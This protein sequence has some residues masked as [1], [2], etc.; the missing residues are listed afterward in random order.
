MLKTLLKK[1][2]LELNRSFFYNSKKGKLRSKLSSAVF[3]LAYA[4]LMI[5]ILGVCFVYLSYTIC[6]PFTAAGLD[7]LYF[8]LM[9]LVAIAL[10]VFGSVFNTYSS[11]YK[12]NDND[13]LLSLPI[14][15]KHILISRL[16]G[17]YLIGLMFSGVVM[18]P[19][20]IV[21]YAVAKPGA[22]AIIGSIL[23]TL[24]ISIFVL[25]LSCLLG[26]VVAKL[27]TRLKN[28]SL[29]IVVLSLL[30]IA[31]YYYIYY[32]AGSMLQTLL[33]SAVVFGEEIK[34]SAAVLYFIGLC[35]AGDIL[36]MLL[37][38]AAVLAMFA[39]MWR[40]LSRSFL[41]IATTS[42]ATA[43]V[44]YRERTAKLR[45]PRAALLYK[46]LRRFLSSSNY[47]L[48]C[49]LGTLFMPICAVLILVKSELLIS[50]MSEAFGMG[51]DLSCAVLALAL[52]FVVAM[53]DITAPSVSLEGRNLWIVQSLPVDPRLVLREKLELHLLLTAIPAL[54][55]SLSICV[56]FSPS[57][58]MA[59][60]STLLPL[61]FALF[62]ALGG[63]AVNLIR[64]NLSWTS[65]VSA[66]KQSF[67][68]LAV[69]LGGWVVAGLMSFAFYK[70]YGKL[71]AAAFLACCC[72]LLALIC[73]L[74]WRTLM[75]RGANKL[76]FLNSN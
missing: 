35:G 45:S 30:F 44:K 53:N 16:I 58:L 65:E 52:C 13:L 74:L 56:V 64:P 33:L 75:T 12:A 19:A 14:P 61:I 21:Y 43:R 70:L 17:V 73:L 57:P 25:I 72:V 60:L 69:L 42:D 26:W 22:L 9:T 50:Y 1:Q 7:W 46:E 47:M 76:R 40:I 6:E 34:D 24:L 68:V 4:F 49:A 54:L 38:T 36:A 20:L 27:S 3:I 18:L 66:V 32:K 29:V 51:A 2:L 10:G 31:A 41:K 15:V 48:N 37:V 55:C 28:R 11:L 62:G 23:L 8:S 59:L 5:G 71:S 39:L 63:L 67:S